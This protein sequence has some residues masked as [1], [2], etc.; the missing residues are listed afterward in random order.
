MLA[1]ACSLLSCLVLLVKCPW[2]YRCIRCKLEFQQ[3]VFSFHFYHKKSDANTGAVDMVNPFFLMFWAFVMVYV[4]CTYGQIV[5]DQFGTFEAQLCQCK[6]YMWPNEVQQMFM[7]MMVNAQ[8]PTFIYGY[9]NIECTR[10]TFQ[11][12]NC[13]TF[14]YWILEMKSINELTVLGFSF[15]FRQFVYHFPISWRCVNS[16]DNLKL[17][18]TLILN[19]QLNFEI[20]L[21]CFTNEGILFTCE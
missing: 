2:C 4:Y 18:S 15:V 12:V 10:Y 5:T 8:Q 14:L 9:G 7:I 1:I 16:Y 6:W 19:Y 17:W 13:P 21:I 11:K 20:Q 3:R